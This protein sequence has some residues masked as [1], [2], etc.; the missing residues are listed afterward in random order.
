MAHF[1]SP[2][3]LFLLLLFVYLYLWL[4]S[5]RGKDVEDDGAVQDEER[6]GT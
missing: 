5:S 1:D 3:L 6:D 4:G 2:L